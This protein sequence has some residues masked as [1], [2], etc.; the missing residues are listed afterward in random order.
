MTFSTSLWTLSRATIAIGTHGSS[1]REDPVLLLS[2]HFVSSCGITWVGLH[3]VLGACDGCY[4]VFGKGSMPQR[5]N[6]HVSK[7]TPIYST[8]LLYKL[9][10][11]IRSGTFS[12]VLILQPADHEL[13]STHDH[14]LT[15]TH[16]HM[17]TS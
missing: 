2:R 1:C 12:C 14:E 6:E 17:I 11:L 5:H 16:D 9:I 10:K 3:Y 15:S 7:L 13:T 4:P 8:K